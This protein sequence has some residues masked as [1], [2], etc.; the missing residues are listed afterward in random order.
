MSKEDKASRDF[1][2]NT[3]SVYCIFLGITLLVA[4]IIK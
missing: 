1:I 3:Y 2:A 4:V